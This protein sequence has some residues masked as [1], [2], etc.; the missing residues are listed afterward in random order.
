MLINKNLNKILLTGI[1]TGVALNSMA[2][3]STTGN[4]ALSGKS[5]DS[6]AAKTGQTDDVMVVNSPKIEK[7][8]GS[9]TTI[10]AADMQKEGGNNFGTIMRYQINLW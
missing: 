6:S 10:T 9:S 5:P 2:A 3:D 7:K 8:A 4:N 1:L